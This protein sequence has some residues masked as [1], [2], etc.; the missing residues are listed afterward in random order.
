MSC[1]SQSVLERGPSDF[2]QEARHSFLLLYQ[3]GVPAL[4]SWHCPSQK[5][6]LHCHSPPLPRKTQ[7]T[8]SVAETQLPSA[9]P[10]GKRSKSE[11]LANQKG[12]EG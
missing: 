5:G 7:L 12:G 6:A 2:L 10:P 4:V 3:G 11:G 9:H 8:E 1:S